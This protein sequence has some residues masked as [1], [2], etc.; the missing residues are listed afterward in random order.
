M[1]VVQINSVC[2][3]GSTGKI[4][5]GISKLLNSQKI[6][7]NILYCCGNSNYAQG[8]KYPSGGIKFQALKSRIFGNFGFNSYLATKKL[9]AELNRIN[10][11]IVHLHNLHSHNCNVELLMDYFRKHHTKLIWTFH[12]CWAFT[13]YCPHFVIAKCDKWKTGCCD[14]AQA[15]SFTWFVDRSH[16]LYH[17]KKDAVSDLNLTIVTPSQWLGGLVKESFFQQYPLQVINNG[18]D[19][20][21]FRPRQSDF[22][23]KYHIPDDKFIILGVAIEWMHRKGTDVFIRLAQR[24]DPNK[25]QIVLVGTDD[26]I[27]RQLP[28]N[29]ISIH[30]TANQAELAEIYSAADLFANP[31][32]E[33]TYPTV[34]LESLACGTPI[35]TFR[36]GGSPECLDEKTGMVVDCD[37]E[38]AFYHAILD[39]ESRR[40]FTAEDCCAR[41]RSFDQQDKFRE[42]IKLYETIMER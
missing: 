26:V 30:R 39:I 28:E 22:R 25:F 41:A 2:G 34:N 36:T 27:D 23:K 38:E 21:I 32:R 4:C 7:N 1:K 42:Y 8:V 35:L 16:W 31:T 14:C 37:D 5:V 40:P 33:D 11:E 13:A 9:I 29:V 10:P 3:Y 17:K 6:E 19:L 15:K 12:D 24:L 18:I 20:E